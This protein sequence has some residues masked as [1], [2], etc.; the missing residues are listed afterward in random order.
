MGG[1]GEDDTDYPTRL[2]R[3]ERTLAL[4]RSSPDGLEA[5]AGGTGAEAW[6]LSE[7]RAAEKKLKSL[8]L[9]LQ[10]GSDIIGLMADWPDWRRAAVTVCPVAPDGTICR[11]LRYDA[12]TGLSFE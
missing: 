3:E 1:G 12:K 9:P 5:W 7:V 8:P 10:D 6:M 2:G 4:A 11:G